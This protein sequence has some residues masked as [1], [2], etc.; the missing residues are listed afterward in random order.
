MIEFIVDLFISVYSYIR[1]HPIQDFVV[2][3]AIILIRDYYIKQQVKKSE[4]KK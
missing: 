4:E 2:I 3:V 1:L